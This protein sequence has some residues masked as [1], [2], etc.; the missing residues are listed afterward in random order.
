MGHIVHHA[1][2]VTSWDDALIE[3]A[4][5]KAVRLGCYVSKVTETAIND[6]RSFLIAPD[7]SK[8]GWEDS[9]NGDAQRNA[10]VVW[11][12]RQRY[13]DGSSALEWVEI[14]YGTDNREAKVTRHEWQGRAPLE[15]AG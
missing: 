9:D 1:I 6:F 5:A 2:V 10:F 12:K 8:S 4:H 14:E 3:R 7:G 15:R 11:A 13:E